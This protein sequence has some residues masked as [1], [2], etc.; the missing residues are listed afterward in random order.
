M[1]MLEPGNEHDFAVEA[2]G[3]ERDGELGTEN[4]QSDQAIVL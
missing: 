3:P 2:L 1:G 4:L